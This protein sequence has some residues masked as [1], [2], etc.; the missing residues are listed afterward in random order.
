[1]NKIICGDALE[2][3]KTL[4]DESVDC[5]ITSP[6]YWALRNYG[7]EGQLG[8]EPTFQ[9]YI[10][11]LC[12]I[13]DEVKRVLKKTGTCWVNMGDTYGGTGDKG[14]WKDPKYVNGRN[15]QSKAINKSATQKSLCQIP[16]RFAIEMCNRGWILR[17][18][19]IWFKPNCMPSSV[20]DRFTVDFEKIFF[21]VKSK[22]YYFETQYEPSLPES[23]EHH[24]KYAGKRYR[25][26]PEGDDLACQ[27]K[28]E[29][30]PP[31]PQ[32]RNKRCVWR[33]TTKPF[34]MWNETYHLSPVAKGEVSDGTMHIVS[35]SCPNCADLFVEVA[36]R[37]YDGCANDFENYIKHIYDYLVQELKDDCVPIDQPLADCYISQNSDYSRLWYEFFAKPRNNE[38]YKKVHALL[39]NLSYNS[40]VKILSYIDDKQDALLLSLLYLGIHGSKILLDD[41]VAHL[42]DKIAC[43]IVDKSSFS[44]STSCICKFY[45]IKTEKSS[46]FAT[47]PPELV[48]TPIKAGCPVNGIVLDP[49]CGSGTTCAVAKKLGRNYIGIEL[50]PAYIEMAKKRI[51][52]EQNLFTLK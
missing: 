11:K 26:K 13:F 36:K 40:F 4:P 43:Y 5:V 22:K 15:G 19:I 12:N 23:I 7:V 32:G 1:M 51:A 20:K 29:H 47:F 21:F 34:T 37:V 48:E 25:N 52:K 17:N 44:Y 38:N 42:L 16:F 14:D 35:P 9:E 18:E 31:N 45:H 41:K 49:L 28:W 8:L 3:L 33:I 46:H 50:N 10:T 30:R 39:T 2:V 27:M 6:P 24:T